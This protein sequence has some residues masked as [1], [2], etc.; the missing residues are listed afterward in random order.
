MAVSAGHIC[1]ICKTENIAGQKQ[2]ECG[3]WLP[4]QDF[5]PS[6][7]KSRSHHKSA[8]AFSMTSS[9]LAVLAIEIDGTTLRAAV[10]RRKLRTITVSN[11]LKLERTA[12]NAAISAEELSSITSRIDGCPKNVVVIRPLAAM[13]EIAMDSKV[14]KKMKP[15]QLKEAA[16][17]EAEPYM[18]FPATE[19]LVGY[20]KGLELNA[21]QTGIW[22]SMMPGDDFQH[23]KKTFD[24]MGYRLKSVLRPGCLLSG[25]SGVWRG[26]KRHGSIGCR[27][28]EY[29]SGRG[30]RR[31]HKQLENTAL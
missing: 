27:P 31:L 17:W 9:L 22:V 12:E 4:E 26:A 25:R 19:S 20:E 2:C 30:G 16:R 1:P 7:V 21:G 23:M 24:E 14:L 3:H 13:V 18:A 15:Y 10:V 11:C 28:A 6:P 5:L 29:Q 8:F